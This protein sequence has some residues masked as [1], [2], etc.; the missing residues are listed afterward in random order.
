VTR[1]ALL[2]C[3]LAAL[4]LLCALATRGALF[5]LLFWLLVVLF[6][7]AWATVL[8][9]RHTLSVT[10][11]LDSDR[12]TRGDQVM[13]R[14]ELRH[15]CPLPG[16]PIR[17]EVSAVSDAGSFSLYVAAAPYRPRHLTQTLYCP[18]VGEY[19]AGVAGAVVRDVFGLVSLYKPLDERGDVLLVQPQT[20]LT[21][22]LAFSPGESDNESI[23][24]RAFEDATL[25]TDLRAFQQGDELKKVHWKLSMRR[26]ELLVRVYEQPMRP[27]ALLLVDCAPPEPSARLGEAGQFLLR[28]AICEAAA[29]VALAALSDGAPVRMPLLSAEPID[30]SAQKSEELPLVLDAL[31]RCAFDGSER[32]ERVLLLE[33]R[34]LRRTGSTAVITSRMN[35]VIADMVL[36]IRRMGPKVRVY[37]AADGED[38]AVG[39]LVQRLMRND[40]E[41][42]SIS[43]ELV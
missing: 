34:R 7:L 19:P 31:A 4:M 10:C 24:S 5:W 1:R 2:L 32:F 15:R 35:P 26:R 18:H 13:L 20:Y 36:R 39:L 23:A 28:D 29:S 25:P 14:I 38:E 27:D 33:T 8:W 16:A 9:T 17:L 3:A 30:I 41:V 12:V 42:V 40:V 11:A 43:A 21:Q 6:A 37:L 22:P